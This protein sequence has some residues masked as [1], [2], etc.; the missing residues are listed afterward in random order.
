MKM[1]LILFSTVLL[2]VLT[3]SC[4]HTLKAPPSSELIY[5]HGKY[6]HQVKV[7][8]V[9]PSRTMDVKGVVESSRESLKVIG[10]SSFG[11]TVFRIDENY[12]TGEV[13]KEFYVDALR[14]NEERVMSF[15]NLLKEVLATRKGVT[16]FEK[17]GAKFVLSNPDQNQIYRTMVIQHPQVNLNIEVTSYEF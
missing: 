16:E 6:Q 10:I 7:Q 17:H 11:T 3:V 15:Y 8:I 9:Q 13:H 5:P 14:R 12:Q 2:T 1:H 4:T